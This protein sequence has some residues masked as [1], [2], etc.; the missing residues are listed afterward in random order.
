VTEDFTKLLKKIRENRHKL[1]VI[2]GKIIYCTVKNDD[3]VDDTMYIAGDPLVILLEFARM[4]KICVHDLFITF[5]TDVSH[6]ITWEEFKIGAKVKLIFLLNA[7]G[8]IVL[9]SYPMKFIKKN[10]KK[11][12][13]YNTILM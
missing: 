9:V 10:I 6:T 2:H 11:Y 4:K 12:Y 5:D 1:S 7:R 8:P 13:F 3:D